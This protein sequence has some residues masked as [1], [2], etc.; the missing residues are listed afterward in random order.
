MDIQ[1]PLEGVRVLE[2]ANYV[3]APA[4]GRLLTDWGAEVIRAETFSGDVWRFYCAN[5]SCPATEEEN[6]GFDMFNANKKDILLNTKTPE[7]LEV[8]FRLLDT[9]DVFITNTRYKSLIKIGLDYDTLKK[10]YPRLIYAL[11]SG[12]GMYG[13]DAD[14]PGYDGVAFFSRSGLLADT[15]EPSGYPTC[16]PGTFGDCTTGTTLFGAI[17]AALLARERTGYGDMVEVSLFGTATWLSGFLSTCAQER[18]GEIYPK[19]RKVMHPI[20]TF[21]RCRDGEWLQLAIM[22]AERYFRPLCTV[23]EIPEVAEDP[24]FSST[25]LILKNRS[26][27]IPILEEA[28]SKFDCDEM[29]RRLASVDIVFDRL[30]HYREVTKDPQAIANQ[31]VREINY[32]NGNTAMAVMTPIR[33]HNIGDMPYHRAP[34]MGEHTDRIL[35]DLGYSDTEITEL[36]KAGAVKQHS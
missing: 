18:Y 4:A 12:Y 19:E 35:K 34:L 6:P 11:V 29:C 1:K 21:Y 24:R 14:K 8:L 9:A 30:R 20:S 33:S 22:E 3:A 36:K 27:L 26:S 10:R 15:A 5:C 13:P 25:S 23:L 31:Y 7:G 28:F 2:L 16:P 17:C 32:S